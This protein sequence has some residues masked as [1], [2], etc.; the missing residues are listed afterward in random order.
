[1]QYNADV[2]ELKRRIREY[3]WNLLEKRNIARFPRPVYGRIPNFIGADK[4]AYNLS[5][6]SVWQRSRIVKVNP[7]AP[8]QPVRLQALL[9]GKTLIMP[10]PK[11]R[12]GFILLDPETIPQNMLRKAATIR[13]A[14]VLGKIFDKEKALELPKIDLIVTGSVAV[15]KYGSR[16]G[17]GGGYAE[18]EYAIFRE[19]DKVNEDTPV[20][21]TIHDLQLIDRR[22][23]RE[24]H[25]LPVDIVVTPTRIIKTIEPYPKPKGIYWEIL[26]KDKIN[27]IPILKW[28]YNRKLKQL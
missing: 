22:L 17:K 28:L 3:V 15:D 4:A 1:M 23:P 8:Q 19:L 20:I 18:L 27:N 14:F 9:Q 7:D 13:G 10:T 16:I 25:D 26:D 5:Q 24:I 12:K 6:M 21:T 11:I 2:K